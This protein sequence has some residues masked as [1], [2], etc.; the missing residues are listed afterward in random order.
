MCLF[1]LWSILNKHA[2]HVIF[3]IFCHIEWLATSSLSYRVFWKNTSVSH[4]RIGHI[5]LNLTYT[6]HFSLF[7][8]LSR[9]VYHR[10]PPPP[11]KPPPEKPPPLPPLLPLPEL[12]VLMVEE[13]AFLTANIFIELF[14]FERLASIILAKM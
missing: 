14:K 4:N 6:F 3:L 1:L 12:I 9:S 5:F 2:R 10:P 11:P 7:T 13:T 8:L